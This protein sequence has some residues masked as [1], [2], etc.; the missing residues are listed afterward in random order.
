MLSQVDKDGHIISKLPD[1]YAGAAELLSAHGVR[2]V[3]KDGHI[4]SKLPNIYVEFVIGV[5]DSF[6]NAE[7]KFNVRPIP[8]PI[9]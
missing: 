3:D 5:K 6:P 8:G 7:G 9:E 2:S 4:I 1:I